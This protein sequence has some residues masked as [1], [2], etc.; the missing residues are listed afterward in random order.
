[1]STRESSAEQAT[2]LSQ[3]NE[4]KIFIQMNANVGNYL[5]LGFT[6]MN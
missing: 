5:V 1:M 2:R 4:L 3:V 6:D